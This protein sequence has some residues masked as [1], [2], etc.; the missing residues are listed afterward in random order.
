MD[1]QLDNFPVLKVPRLVRLVLRPASYDISHNAEPVSLVRVYDFI[2]TKLRVYGMKL[3]YGSVSR[4]PVI[5]QGEERTDL[6]YE[7]RGSVSKFEITDKVWET[8]GLRAT[9]GF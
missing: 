2:R 9:Y 7:L 1:C 8:D 3:K 4:L 6:E 5:E